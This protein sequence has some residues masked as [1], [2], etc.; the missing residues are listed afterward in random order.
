MQKVKYKTHSVKYNFIMNFILTAS[1]F[2]FPL[3]TFPYV[4]RVLGAAGNGKIA[5]AAS[6]ANYFIMIASLGIPTYGIRA[7]AQVR[8]DKQKLSKTA[9]EI[10]LINMFVT[11]IVMFT[12]T[13]LLVFL[14]NFKLYREL[15]IINGI[16]VMLNMFGIN[17]LFQALE[18]YDYITIRSIIF[19]IISIVL[20]FL[21]V[22]N[23]DDYLKYSAITVFAAVGSYALNFYRAKKII[24]FKIN[25][26]L[27]FK[28]HLKP[29]FTLFAQSLAVS[30]YTNLDVVMLGVLKGDLDVGYYNAAIK[31]KAILLS[32]VTSLGNVL[33]PRM[34]YYVKE[35]M[36][37]QFNVMATKALNFTL[38]LSIPLSTYF[39]IYGKEVILFIA[40]NDYLPAVLA[41]QFITFAVIPNGLTGVLGIQI[42]TSQG[43]EKFVLIS[44]I[45]G[46][47]IDF[48]L[49]LVLIP[50]FGASG[51][52]FATMIAEFMVLFVQIIYTRRMLYSIRKSIRVKYY[53]LL[54]LVS[55]IVLIAIGSILDVGSV[56]L[57]LVMS[58]IIYFGLY[59]IE[60]CIIK[61]ELIYKVLIQL[62]NKMF[63]RKGI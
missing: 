12:Y 63:I 10:F 33:L 7:C 1:Q 51:A 15:L 43:K 42:L 11:L 24:D 57:T 40:G 37:N 8:N 48:I 36:I 6:V 26:K 20:M 58:C 46:A 44:V 13:V 47:I 38:L 49:N 19:K 50:I 23:A 9:K 53:V 2:I 45:V 18:Q 62:K 55:S 52:A 25:C 59:F 30:I 61:E 60:L 34:S 39:C 31:I 5:F 32:L 14:P 27:E 16:N 3:I 56:F 22:H 17:W 41:M 54:T 28:I 4:S 21:L 29:I 35:N